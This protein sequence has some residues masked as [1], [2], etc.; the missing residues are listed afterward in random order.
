MLYAD[1]ICIVS[2]SSSGLQKLLNICHDHCEL[3]DL[4]FNA[5]QSMCMYF[6]IDINKQCGLP[7]IYLRISIQTI[8]KIVILFSELEN[9]KKHHM[10]TKLVK[11]NIRKHKVQP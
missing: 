6:S 3:H 10:P 1:D 9:A 8:M 7:V 5:K 2:L 4:T 11:F